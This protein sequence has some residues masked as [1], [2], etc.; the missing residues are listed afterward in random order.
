MIKTLVD[1]E[2][3][4]GEIDIDKL[5]AGERKVDDEW[6]P[7]VWCVEDWAEY[8]GCYNEKEDCLYIG[9]DMRFKYV[10]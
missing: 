3:Y 6:V 9:N 4:Y 10:D 5:E 7:N 2:W 8:N 1:S